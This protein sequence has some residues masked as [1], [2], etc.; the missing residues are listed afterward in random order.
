MAAYYNEFDPFA[1]AWLRNLISEGLIADGHVDDRSI[2]DVR[3]SDLDGYTQLHFFAGLGGWSYAL[4]LAGVPDD[5]PLWTGSCPC[6]PFSV[7]GAGGGFDDER[8]LWPDWHWLISQC[9]PDL[10]LGEQVDSPL[11]RSWLD[12]VLT[13]LEG[14]GYTVGPVVFPS[15]G[16]G[17][18]N[19]R[20]RMFWMADAATQNE[21]RRGIPGPGEGAGAFEKRAPGQPPGLGESGVGGMADADGGEPRAAGYPGA[22]RLQRG[23]EQRREP[24][25]GGALD[26]MADAESRGR[27]EH[28]LLGQASC[29]REDT[30]QPAQRVEVGGLGHAGHARL[31]HAEP[32]GVGGTGWREEGRA[33]AESGESPGFWSDYLIIPCRDGKYRRIPAS[34]DPAGSPESGILTLVDGLP[35]HL[36]QVWL[37]CAGGFPLTKAKVPGRVGLLRGA[38]NSIV[39]QVAAEF[40]RAYMETEENFKAA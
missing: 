12:L 1:A 38:G 6:Q 13:D 32:Q 11:G 18:P 7:A 19:L 3:P 30:G 10:V 34:A 5:Y 27:G 15:A 8:H 37:D 29:R 21:R 2:R 26:G 35:E 33:V 36:A 40:I 28:G 4:R 9:R 16:V 23:G 31:P 25:D 22:E 39:P 17:A 14:G 24:Q 20:H